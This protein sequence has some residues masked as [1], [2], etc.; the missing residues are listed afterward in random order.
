VIPERHGVRHIRLSGMT[1]SSASVVQAIDLML[2]W[3]AKNEPIAD[4]FPAAAT[5]PVSPSRPWSSTPTCHCPGNSSGIFSASSEFLKSQYRQ[6]GVCLRAVL[7]R[8]HTP[9]QD[10]TPRSLPAKS[11]TEISGE[12][13]PIPPPKGGVSGLGGHPEWLKDT[14]FTGG[15]RKHTCPNGWWR[16]TQSGAN[17]SLPARPRIPCSPGEIQGNSRF[18]S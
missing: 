9:Y 10:Q 17:P 4:S 12:M 8:G 5:R 16:S 6:P 7:R 15:L 1:A 13:G 18:R 11:R 3:Q 2:P 14:G